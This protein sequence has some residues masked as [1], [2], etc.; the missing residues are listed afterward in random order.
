MFP[1]QGR[2]ILSLRTNYFDFFKQTTLA[3][4]ELIWGKLFVLDVEDRHSWNVQRGP[5]GLGCYGS[6]NP[7]QALVDS[8]KMA[9]GSNFF[10]HYMVDA[11]GYY[12]NK[13]TTK[14]KHESPYY[15]REPRFY[16]SILYDSTVWQKRFEDL[17]ARD[18][19]G[20]YERRTRIV[21]QG[22]VEVSKTFGIDTRNSPFGS[23]NGGYTG[24]LTK[25]MMDDRTY[26]TGSRKS[27]RESVFILIS[28]KSQLLKRG[29]N[30]VLENQFGNL[31]LSF[32]L[33]LI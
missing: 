33:K 25:K 8:Y 10:D 18:P 7:T 2:E 20:I 23:W 14:Y 27:F 22:G 32:F 29:T 13:G 12:K 28:A 21:M 19:L 17:A 11:D 24:Y 9:D 15:D 30:Q 5:N 31:Y 16:A 4:D 26:D 1:E 6:N 3:N